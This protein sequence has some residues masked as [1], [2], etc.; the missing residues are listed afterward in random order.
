MPKIRIT[1]I[2]NTGLNLSTEAPN[3]VYIPGLAV[4]KTDP[5]LFTSYSELKH[6]VETLHN[7]ENFDVESKSWVMAKRLLQLGLPVLYQGFIS[8]EGQSIPTEGIYVAEM[9]EEPVEGSEG[10]E[11]HFVVSGEEFIIQNNGAS[12]RTKKKYGSGTPAPL[13]YSV[14]NG[15]VSIPSSTPLFEGNAQTITLDYVHNL[16]NYTMLI[17]KSGG[18]TITNDDWKALEDKNLYNIRFLTTGEFA[19]PTVAMMACASNR[20]DCVALIDHEEKLTQVVE[21]S[22][23]TAVSKVRGF[24][25]D[26]VEDLSVSEL[27]LRNKDNAAS[28]SAGFTPWF[29]SGLMKASTGLNETF[30]A[31]FGYLCAFARSIQNNNPLWKSIAGSFRGIITEL[32]DVCYKYTNSECEVLGARGAQY[33]VELD[34][35]ADNV[36]IAINPIALENP[37]GYLIWGNR[38]LRENNGNLKASS[39]LNDRMLVTELSK[40]LYRAGK[41]YTFEQNTDVL[42]VNYKSEITPTLDRMKSNEGIEDYEILKLKTDKKARI[43]ARVV[44]TPIDGLEDWDLEIYMTDSVEVVE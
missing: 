44:I 33:E 41:K 34:D 23:D 3:I 22:T 28:F 9:F 25:E 37:F 24:F 36:G 1:E 17:K 26:L 4:A 2:D 43:K 12:I 20:G 35:T 11:L 16:V 21:G 27:V 13:E 29:K 7:P 18:I 42:W 8:T 32:S 39:I 31:S 5:V 6:Y 30:P 38:T 15:V 40:V 10:T 19:C 14:V